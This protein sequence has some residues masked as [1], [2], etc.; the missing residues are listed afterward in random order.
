[1]A[2]FNSNP[3]AGQINQLNRQINQ[4][5]ADIN[6]K[7]TEIGRIA[8]LKYM[9]MIDDPDAKRLAGEIDTMLAN[10]QVMTK[11]INEL[12]GLRECVGCHMQIGTN[13]AFC[14][15][16]GTKQPVAQQPVQPVQQPMMQQPMQQPMQPQQPSPWAPPM[17]QPPVPPQGFVPQGAPMMQQ[18]M[19]TPMPAPVPVP[20]E[21]PD[22]P[23]PS[24]VPEPV[25]APIEEP[26]PAP[27]PEQPEQ[28]ANELPPI[29]E[30]QPPEMQ[31]LPE[32]MP[33]PEPAPIPETQQPEPV[34]AAANAP[35]FIFCTSCGNKE[36]AGTRFCSECGAVLQ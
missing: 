32:P 6:N 22:K 25:P 4:H 18:P 17:Q 30:Y 13:V 12:K 26:T 1:M 11:Q 33:I 19:P 5:L 20:A 16:C 3:N 7:Y 31:P 15:N 29:P 27:E 8:K 14:P 24:P 10:L 9:D 21:M 2:F 36:V 23:A 28:P 34:P 35:Q